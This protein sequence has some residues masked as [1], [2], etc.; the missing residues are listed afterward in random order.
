MSKAFIIALVLSGLVT[1][2]Y[3]YMEVKENKKD[4]LRLFMLLGSAICFGIL[5]RGLIDN[6]R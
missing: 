4:R 6:L 2:I 1:Q 5:L 3:T